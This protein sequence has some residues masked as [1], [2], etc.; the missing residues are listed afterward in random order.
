[1][2]R[3]REVQARIVHLSPRLEVIVRPNGSLTFIR[4]GRDGY[5]LSDREAKLLRAALEEGE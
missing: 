4:D 2:T 1:V 3:L 5:P